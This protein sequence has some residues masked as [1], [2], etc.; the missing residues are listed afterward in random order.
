MP[1]SYY[2]SERVKKGADRRVI[3]PQ[4]CPAPNMTAYT[5]PPWNENSEAVFWSYQV[6]CASSSIVIY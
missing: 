2:V 6:T 3:K 5:T 1:R 4:G